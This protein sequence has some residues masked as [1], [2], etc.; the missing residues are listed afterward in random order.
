MKQALLDL[1]ASA[2]PWALMGWATVYFFAIY[3]LFA[4]LAWALA[5]WLCRPIERREVRPAQLTSE[6]RNSLRSIVLFGMGMVVPWGLLQ[7]GWADI[8][9]HATLPEIVLDGVLLVLWNDLHFY[10]MH[11]LLHARFR[12]L[13]GLH[14]Q[15]IAAT[16]FAAYSMSAGEALLLGSVMPMAMLVHD[17]SIESLALLPVWSICINVLSH[18]NCDLFPRARATS[19]LRFIRHHQHHHSHYHGNY[20]FLFI[21]LDQWFGTLQSIDKPGHS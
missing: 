9:G 6:Q 12:K 11:R 14:H 3:T 16:P 20:G 1:M 8:A 17:F 21:Q 19:L 7:L 15:S 18:A 10:G 2:S 5:R 13:H 4:S